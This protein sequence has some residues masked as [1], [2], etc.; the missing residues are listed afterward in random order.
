MSPSHWQILLSL[1]IINCQQC[2]K[3]TKSP[4]PDWNGLLNCSSESSVPRWRK[5]ICSAN[6]WALKISWKRSSCWLQLV[7]HFGTHKAIPDMNT[8]GDKYHIERAATLSLPLLQIFF[9]K[10]T[11]GFKLTT[12]KTFVIVNMYWSVYVP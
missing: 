10:K 9:H 8:M 11:K 1:F 12:N 4:F 5:K 7:F 3:V 6:R 2:H